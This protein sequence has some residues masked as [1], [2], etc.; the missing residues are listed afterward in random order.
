MYSGSLEL[1]SIF[2]RIL[3]IW[4]VTVFS[5]WKKGD[6]HTFSYISFIENTLPVLEASN[7]KIP[8]SVAVSF[9]G[10][11]RS[12]ADFR[13][14][15]IIKSLITILSFKFTFSISRGFSYLLSWDLTLAM[16]SRWLK[17]LVI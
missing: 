4:T 12:V 9:K 14:V 1:I 11:P 6:F 15:S 8:Y 7:S 16:S 17:G 10:S 2:S 13:V 5:L 3:R